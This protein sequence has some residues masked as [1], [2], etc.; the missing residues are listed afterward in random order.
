MRRRTKLMT[1]R[2]RSMLLVAFL[3]C[4]THAW[5]QTVSI[6]STTGNVIAAL[7][8]DGESHLA[9]FGGC[10][11]HHQLPLTLISSDDSPITANGLMQD[12]ANNIGISDGKLVLIA[13]ASKTINNHLSLSLPKGY[14]FTSYK[15]TIAYLKDMSTGE[16]EGDVS[17]LSEMDSSFSKTYTSASIQESTTAATLSRTSM[18]KG[19]MGNVLYFLQS[20]SDDKMALVRL[21]SFEVTYECSDPFVE[22]LTPSVTSEG[23][24]C[25]Q[26][27]F[28]TERVD[29]GAISKQ[30]GG[31]S[32]YTSFK[33]NYNNVADLKAAFSIYDADG[34]KDGQAD[35]STTKD[36]HISMVWQNQTPAFG[37]KEDTYY[38]ET[39][40]KAT[41]QGNAEIALG[42][43][44]TGAKLYY[45]NTAQTTTEATLGSDLYIMND[46]GQY[47]NSSLE[48][49]STPVL[50][51]SSQD[52]KISTSSTYLMSKTT[53]RGPKKSTSLSTTTDES[54]ATTYTISGTKL[55]SGNYVVSFTSDGKGSYTG[56]QVS[57]LGVTGT[58]EES[59]YVLSLYDKTGENIAQQVTVNSSNPSGTIE[60]DG[61][62][63]DAVKLTVTNLKG[64]AA[65]VGAA[66]TLEALNPYIQK[67]D[68]V[69]TQIDG[70]N[71]LSQQY[72]SKDFAIGTN[73]V[74]TFKVPTNFAPEGK[75]VKF[76]FDN[77]TNKNADDTYG[78]LSGS[79]NSRYHYVKSPY[80]DLIDE[81]LQSHRSEAANYTYT[82]KVCTEQVADQQFKVN[83]TDE[84]SIGTQTSDKTFYLTDQRFAYKTFADQG[85]T[86]QSVELT[87]GSEQD[88]YLITC[89]ETRYNIA[90]T[91]V[92]RHSYYA[93][94]KTHIK[95]ETENYQPVLSYQPLYDHAMLATGYDD[96]AYVGV[97]I[98]LKDEEGT[99]LTD[100]SK[101]YVLTKQVMEQLK[102]DI[103]NKV[104]G[105]PVDAKHVLYVDASDLNTMLSGEESEWGQLETLQGMIGTNALIL[106]PQGTT[107][108]G[109]NIASKTSFGD[110]KA[111]ND[112]VLTDQQ[113][114][115]APY[116]IRIDAAREVM[117]N[118]LLTKN[119]G[120]VKWFST[121]LPF[122]IAT[123]ENGTC[124]LG[125]SD[126]TLTF[127]QMNSN[128]AL[129]NIQTADND[130]YMADAHF[131]PITGQ[132]TTT[133]NM[134]YLVLLEN[135]ATEEDG[136][137]VLFSLR[138][139][140]STIMKTPSTNSIEGGTAQ[141]SATRS[142]ATLTHYGTYSG[143]QIDKQSGVFYFAKDRFVSSLNLIS[144]YPNVYIMPFRTWY[145]SNGSN[146]L[147]NI[148]YLNISTDP[149][150][151]TDI[152]SVI[153]DKSNA[154][155][156]VS[157]TKGALTVQATQ[158]LRAEV[159][160][161]S[162][163][164][165]AT[166]NLKAGESRTIHMPSGI[167]I[168]NGTKVMVR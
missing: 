114:F 84:F 26:V 63:N 38:I 116:D 168:I 62:N 124:H 27:P 28:E 99:T 71:K 80:Y 92:P 47:M 48:F 8:Y 167:Y 163:Q 146:A 21:V 9:N 60:V 56:T 150:V 19:D 121:I 113:P 59:E 157:T 104:S 115:Y 138:Q 147:A 137:K 107:S 52:G 106:L 95:L 39:P 155:F 24:D 142:A 72:I 164:K 136:D 42:Y 81:N 70:G 18:T 94:Y 65:Y 15:M 90:P 29:L 83:N 145:A 36:R 125:E 66:L 4:F 118:R 41:T 11:I 143:E 144:A 51:Q 122:T 109:N 135:M 40:T 74:V 64:D 1:K 76:S 17:V 128:D 111:A 101:G 139:N 119:N 30:T 127:Y 162:G 148:A 158:P 96:N 98:G 160:N 37:L 49:T 45:S 22:T 110:F 16:K 43:R 151:P 131:T 61:M 78:S 12:H 126:A 5:S 67:T 25:M 100:P 89:D 6:N 120:V 79:G 130:D 46:E 34:I 82:D 7:S 69:G 31:A 88:C 20:H 161:I 75:K 58:T 149:S 112:I 165:M 156:A 93:F 129:D 54:K 105:A 159:T 85:G 10:W 2:I 140:G 44:I 102:N 166:V 141:A 73:G 57:V 14:R 86:F 77:L 32:K 154:G 91:T 108:T 87:T 153:G 50:W 134:P 103:T 132:A 152:S 3:T 33:Y 97:H 13:G 117:Y 123:D 133:A 35:P 53:G 68:V 23:V 55:Y